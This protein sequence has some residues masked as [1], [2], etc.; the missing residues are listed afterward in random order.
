MW[1]GANAQVTQL[2]NVVTNPEQLNLSNSQQALIQQV[3]SNEGTFDY[4]IVTFSNPLSV[5]NGTLLSFTVPTFE[6][7][8]FTAEAQYVEIHPDGGYTWTGQIQTVGKGDIMFTITPGEPPTGFI[9]LTGRYYSITGLSEQL[10]ILTKQDLSSYIADDEIFSEPPPSSPPPNIC[11]DPA[12]V[13]I[14]VL[15]TPEARAQLNLLPASY[16]TNAFANINFSLNQSGVTNK[17]VRFQRHFAPFTP[18]GGCNVFQIS[19][20]DFVPINLNPTLKNLRDTYKADAIIILS[21][22][23]TPGYAGVSVQGPNPN[24]PYGLILL[25]YLMGPRFTLSHEFGHM[26]GAKHNRLGNDEGDEPTDGTIKHGHYFQDGDGQEQWTIMAKEPGTTPRILHYSNPE[27]SYN[28][29]PTGTPIDNN[30]IAAEGGLCQMSAP[31]PNSSCTY[32]SD[33]GNQKTLHSNT[34]VP[35]YFHRLRQWTITWSGNGTF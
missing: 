32:S 11:E 10:A 3:A 6:S 16:L 13:D 25:D 9:R 21:H 30:A 20:Q 34:S 8:T 14:L 18:I 23:L 4:K 26:F 22:C 12:F 17:Y 29:V 5:L 35:P 15:E 28:G 1:G 24:K 33:H 7:Q 31:P 2:F 27:V 19:I